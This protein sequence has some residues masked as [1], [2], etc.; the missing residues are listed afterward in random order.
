MTGTVSTTGVASRPNVCSESA[1]VRVQF[2][3]HARALPLLIAG[4]PRHDKQTACRRR[5]DSSWDE[6]SAASISSQGARASCRPF[7]VS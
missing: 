4:A 1:R 3:A 6:S 2:V 5:P 7:T